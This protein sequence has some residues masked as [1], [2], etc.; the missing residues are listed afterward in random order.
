MYNIRWLVIQK[1]H[2]KV[3]YVVDLSGGKK[4]KSGSQENNYMTYITQTTR[5][6]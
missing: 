2:P 1:I 3:N 6:F 5:N 4:H